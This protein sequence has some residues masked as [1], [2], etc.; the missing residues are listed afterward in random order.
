MVPQTQRLALPGTVD[1]ER[2]E[3]A[4]REL[5][6]REE[7][8]HFLAVVQ[9]VEEHDRGRAAFAARRLKEIR[10]ERRAFVRNVDAFEIGVAAL[11]PFLRAAQAVPVDA[12]LLLARRHHA[13]AREVVHPRTQVVIAC[14]RMMT[15]RRGFVGEFLDARGHRAPLLPPRV[16]LVGTLVE[17]HHDLVDLAE[18]DRPCTAPC[19]S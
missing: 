5:G 3:T 15:G 9:S 14:R 8:V 13:L 17:A 7:H 11:E 1:R 19:L 10:G 18:S 12:H 16:R 6:A 4:E 2:V